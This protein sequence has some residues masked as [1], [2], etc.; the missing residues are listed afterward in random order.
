[1]SAHPP[2]WF[3][4]AMRDGLGRTALVCSFAPA[5]DVA[6]EVFDQWI[7]DLWPGR[8]WDQ[9]QDTPRIAEA[10]RRLRVGRKDWPTPN[11]FATTIASIPRKKSNAPALPAPAK[12]GNSSF[13]DAI[14]DDLARHLHP[15]R[16]TEKSNDVLDQNAE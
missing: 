3:D 16:K 8:D 2:K 14:F 12:R 15:A 4:A 6:A 10:F 7:D 13:V 1:M 9:A 11:E 5:E